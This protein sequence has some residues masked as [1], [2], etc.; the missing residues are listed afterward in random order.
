MLERTLLLASLVLLA[1][2]ATPDQSAASKPAASKRVAAAEPEEEDAPRPAE[3]VPVISPVDGLI[4][5]RGLPQHLSFSL[6]N[7]ASTPV[8]IVLSGI[9]HGS[10]TR[11]S[12]SVGE[13]QWW[14]EAATEPKMLAL[15]EALELGAGEVGQLTV[16]LGAWPQAAIDAGEVDAMAESYRLIGKFEVDGVANEVIV[17]IKRGAARG[18]GAGR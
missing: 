5:M 3:V 6:A 13:I 11:T 12:L 14:G 17:V 18:P 8:S 1:C 15:D 7:A 16:Y 10:S 2:P 9:D 4:S